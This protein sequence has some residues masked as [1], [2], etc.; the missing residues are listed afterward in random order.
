MALPWAAELWARIVAYDE[1]LNAVRAEL[2]LGYFL[3]IT[4]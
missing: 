1:I 3:I 2:G 4:G